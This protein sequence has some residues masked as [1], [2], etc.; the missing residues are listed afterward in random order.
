MLRLGDTFGSIK[1]FV[2]ILLI[3]SLAVAGCSGGGAISLGGNLSL[4]GGSGSGGGSSSN[5]AQIP[6]SW[7]LL[8]AVVVLVVAAVFANG[9]R[10]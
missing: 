6:V 8:T 9:R 7:I 1:S 4:G 2:V 5:A 3:V 10:G